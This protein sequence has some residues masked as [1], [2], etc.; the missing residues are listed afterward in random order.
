MKFNYNSS[1]S[2]SVFDVVL[3]TYSP[4]RSDCDRSMKIEYVRKS[5]FIVQSDSGSLQVYQQ[6]C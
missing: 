1:K 4:Q 3:Q 6:K 5:T 2:M